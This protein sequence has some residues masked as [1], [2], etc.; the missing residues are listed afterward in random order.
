MKFSNAKYAA[1]YMRENLSFFPVHPVENETTD[2]DFGIFVKMN[3]KSNEWLKSENVHGGNAKK[4][5]QYAN[6]SIAAHQIA[7]ELY[8]EFGE[9]E[10]SVFS[11]LAAYET[12]AFACMFACMGKFGKYVD[13]KKKR[14]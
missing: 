14:L 4:P 2:K 7:E 1:N 5:G 11:S 8:N 10:K 6:I 13:S 12:L 3:F 9:D